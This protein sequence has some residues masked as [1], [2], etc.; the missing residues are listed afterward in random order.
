MPNGGDKN[1]VRV[2][3]AIDGFRGRYGHWPKRVRIMPVSFVDLVSHVLTPLGFALVS[4]V[5]ELIPEEDAEMIADDGT[6]A[7]FNYGREE[8]ENAVTP[9]TREWFGEAVLRDDLDW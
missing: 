6:G 1:W 7:E 5:V 4:S 2:C 9:R 8:S 3:K